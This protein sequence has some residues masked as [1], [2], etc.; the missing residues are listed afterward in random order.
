M[1]TSKHVSCWPIL[2]QKA[3]CRYRLPVRP[4]APGTEVP[5]SDMEIMKD[6]PVKSLIT[7]PQTGDIFF[8][9]SEVQFGDDDLVDRDNQ[10]I[11]LPM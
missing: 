3:V 5:E 1:I 10:H 8:Q 9:R 11:W 6:M 4:V 7:F 2:L